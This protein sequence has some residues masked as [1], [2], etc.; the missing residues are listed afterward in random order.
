M[1]NSPVPRLKDVAK[2][3]NVSLA[4]ASR[5]LRGD[6]ERFGEETCRRVIEA[7]QQLGWRRNLLVNGMQTGK[8]QTIG[9]MIP[10][11][12][13]FW[14]SVLSGIHD[15]LAA[16]DYL[17]IT[18]WIGSLGDMPHFEKDE[19]EGLRQINRL[20]DRRVDGLIMWPTFSVAYYD[21]FPEFV[22]RRVP[23]AVIDHYSTVADSVETDEEKAT[24]EVADHLLSLGHRRVACLS[25]RETESQT[26][27]VKRRS[28]FEDA[29]RQHPDT[30]VQSW[31]LNRHGTNGLAVA[32]EVLKSDLQPTAVFAVSDH[33]AE[34]LYE[35]AAALNMKIPGDVSIVGFA[36]LDFA[37]MMDPP[38]TTMRQKPHEIGSRAA[39]LIMERIDGIIPNNAA[40][41]TIKVDASLILRDSTAAPRNSKTRVGMR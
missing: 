8:T 10:P 21:H 13:S 2:A 33:E 34:F 28:S 39:R 29:M 20:L 9:V 40:P 16:S 15:T 23:V 31:R 11:Y 18:I 19:D 7:S 5:I 14:V 1:A 30:V 32:Q 37:E 22:E 35:A 25:S 17:P 3:A 41:T 26:W 38:L 6:R 27:A 12:D 36:D 4:A 24:R